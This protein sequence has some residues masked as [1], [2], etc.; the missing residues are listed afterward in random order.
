MNARIA[1]GIAT[2]PTSGCLWGYKSWA[3]AFSGKDEKSG[4][5]TFSSKLNF[6]R[7]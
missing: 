7:H 6:W 4:I 5:F 2:L 3:S 1:A